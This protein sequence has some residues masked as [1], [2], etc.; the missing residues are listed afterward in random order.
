[1]KVYLLLSILF[2][3][4]SGWAQQSLPKYWITFTDKKNTPYTLD[5]PLEYLS[6]RSLDRREKQGIG[7]DSSDLPVN[8]AYIESVKA[9]GIRIINI[10]KWFNG[11]L[12]EL[13]CTSYLDTLRSMSFIKDEIIRVKPE[14]TMPQEKQVHKF[15]SETDPFMPAY[16]HSY[17][18]IRMLNGH[19]LHQ[20][21][22]TGEGM[23]ISLLD[24]G[25][26][27]ANTIS[28][29]QHL[30][31]DGRV[32]AT[33]DFVKDGN[34]FFSSHSHGTIVLSALAG[35]EPQMLLGSAPG[36]SYALIRTEDD[37]SEYLIEE[38]N[39]VCGAEF[40]DSIGSDVINSSLGYTQFD[41]PSQNHSVED[42]DG[43]TTPVA[44]AASIASEKGIIV[45]VSAGNNGGGPWR[46]IGSPADADGILAVGAT[47]SLGVIAYFSSRGPSADGRIKPDVSAMGLLTY[48]QSPD[49]SFIYAS[50]T[51]ISSPLIAGMAACLWQANPGA[52]N[53]EIIDK[54][55]QS[56]D[57]YFGS[58]SI[59]GNGIPDFALS[60]R[61]LLN[62]E[63]LEVVK[64]VPV[65]IFPNPAHNNIYLRI[66]REGIYGIEEAILRFYDIYGRLNNEIIV[67]VAGEL[68]VAEIDIRQL[69]TGIYYLH[70]DFTDS[71]Y[72]YIFSKN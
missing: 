38:Y 26:T 51:S 23:L 41:D 14:I 22:Y 40:A 13:D 63:E 72:K 49:N 60:D 5:K 50:G 6:S 65:N 35:Y 15:K 45:V 70:I 71:N 20:Q 52:A 44:R 8:P 24:A 47:D 1:M 66:Y 53:I 54:I 62:R 56:S 34:A 33:K 57:R 28:S 36:A 9:K 11:A 64:S 55:R 4:Y 39:W 68:H 61:M 25:Y 67:P 7:I 3:S 37:S 2:I 31:E 48:S 18:Q 46:K 59:Y 29:L 16:G 43:K 10:S 32:I 69:R 58:D 42:L 17:N 30:W 21:G 12:V 27:N 19:I